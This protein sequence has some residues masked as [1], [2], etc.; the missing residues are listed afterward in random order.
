MYLSSHY[1]IL[2]LNET[3]QTEIRDDSNMIGVY[4]VINDKPYKVTLNSL[5]GMSLSSVTGS[6][7]QE[8]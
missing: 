1:I 2:F 6:G 3:G 8:S 7:R 4:P 5:Q